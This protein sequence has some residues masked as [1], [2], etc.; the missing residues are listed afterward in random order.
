[1]YGILKYLELTRLDGSKIL[2]N[3]NAI[4]AV[5]LEYNNETMIVYSGNK[6]RVK[7]TYDQVKSHLMFN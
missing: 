1:M 6:Q 5:Y 4:D 7:E 2:I 3:K